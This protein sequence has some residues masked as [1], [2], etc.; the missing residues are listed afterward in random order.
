MKDDGTTYSLAV[1]TVGIGV[2][3]M[4]VFVQCWIL[5]YVI[6]FP[7]WNIQL[8]YVFNFIVFDLFYILSL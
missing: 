2:V 6:F 4:Y 3:T 7:F 8:F 5:K 1:G